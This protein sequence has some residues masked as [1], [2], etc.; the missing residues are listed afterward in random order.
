MD[1]AKKN[2]TSFYPGTHIRSVFKGTVFKGSLQN[3]SFLAGK[4]RNSNYVLQIFLQ[5]IAKE[6]SEPRRSKNF[7][8]SVDGTRFFVNLP[9]T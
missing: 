9:K 2:S 5:P 8:L 4:P 6:A 3:L 1:F 7:R